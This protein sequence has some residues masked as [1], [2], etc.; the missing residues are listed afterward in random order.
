ML[1]VL[2]QD[3]LKS[4]ILVH[5]IVRA[6]RVLLSQLNDPRFNHLFIEGSDT[7]D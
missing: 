1:D 3:Y 7:H 4:L 2:K 5:T 6:K